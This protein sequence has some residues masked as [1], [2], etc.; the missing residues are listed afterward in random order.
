MQEK[1]VT[2]SK[3]FSPLDAPVFADQ[4][5]LIYISSVSTLG[6]TESDGW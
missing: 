6:P 1:Q 4:Q 2:F 5:A 3:G